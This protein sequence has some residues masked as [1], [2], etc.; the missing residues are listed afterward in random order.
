M[1]SWVQRI[2][3]LWSSRHSPPKNVMYVALSGK[4]RYTVSMHNGLMEKNTFGLTLHPGSDADS[5]SLSLCLAGSCTIAG[6]A[7]EKNDLIENLSG[8][9]S[10]LAS[11][12]FMFEGLNSIWILCAFQVILGIIQLYP[13]VSLAKKKDQL[14]V[15]YRFSICVLL[16]IIF[17]YIMNS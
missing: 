10:S 8:H 3:H 17:K 1:C 11:I 16:Q 2:P 13:T 12:V 4:L 14:R 5:S 6:G 15:W 7:Q 9:F